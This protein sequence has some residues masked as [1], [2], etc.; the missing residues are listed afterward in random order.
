[1][2]T[3]PD[4]R[5]A[6][7]ELVKAAWARN[8]QRTVELVDFVGAAIAHTPPDLIERLRQAL[9]MLNGGPDDKTWCCVLGSDLRDA[10]DALA[11]IAQTARVP[12]SMV[13]QSGSTAPVAAPPS[14]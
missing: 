3:P 2:S 10:V 4:L 12:Q 14:A 11:A 5:A 8:E 1:M 13:N 7:Q 6:L 9:P